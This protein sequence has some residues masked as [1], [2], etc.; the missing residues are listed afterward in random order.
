[1][2]CHRLVDENTPP[3]IVRARLKRIVGIPRAVD[4]ER[5]SG[6][7]KVEGAF[8]VLRNIWADLR[9]PGNRLRSGS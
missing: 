8:Y 3:D 9:M 2:R 5:E 7:L 1:M 4:A 6:F